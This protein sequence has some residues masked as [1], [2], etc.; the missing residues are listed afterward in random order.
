MTSLTGRLALIRMEYTRILLRLR[1]AT[2]R[3]LRARMRTVSQLRW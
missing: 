2:R 3:S 1:K